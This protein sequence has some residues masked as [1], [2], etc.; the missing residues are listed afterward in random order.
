MCWTFPE[1]DG[2]GA[3]VGIVRRYAGPG[4]NK[5]TLPGSA[6]GLTVPAGWPGA[7]PVLVPEGASDVLALHLCGVTAVGRPSNTGGAEHLAR[8]LAGLD[9]GRPV[10]VLG[11]NDPK[12]DGSWPGREGAE[13]VAPRLAAALGRPVRVAFPPDGAKDCREWV[14][15]LLADQ[16]ECEDRELV[17]RQVLGHVAATGCD[18]APPA[19]LLDAAPGRPRRSAEA[20]IAAAE[21]HIETINGALWALAATVAELR[22]QHCCDAASRM[23]RPEPGDRICANRG[24]GGRPA[25]R[26]G[27][28]AVPCASG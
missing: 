5:F 24:R 8:L 1:C 20:L 9:P 28:S 13:A 22:Q 6:R 26:R 7:G 10:Y 19:T 14:R 15:G 17:G 25:P 27:G 16:G 12:G 23:V 18:V 4:K 21:R 3:V 2:A 11:E